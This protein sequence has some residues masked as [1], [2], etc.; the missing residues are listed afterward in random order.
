MN[1]RQSKVSRRLFEEKD[2]VEKFFF[3]FLFFFVFNGE[4]IGRWRGRIGGGERFYERRKTICGYNTV[5]LK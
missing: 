3:C 1:V 5:V 2:E 4:W